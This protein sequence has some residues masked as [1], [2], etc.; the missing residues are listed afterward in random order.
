MNAW[1]EYDILLKI[2]RNRREHPMSNAQYLFESYDRYNQFLSLVA[3]A[4]YIGLEEQFGLVVDGDFHKSFE[5]WL[6]KEHI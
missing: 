2:C 1:D 4:D 6:A 5:K 3:K